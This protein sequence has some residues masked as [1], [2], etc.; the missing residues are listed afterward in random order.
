SRARTDCSPVACFRSNP[1]PTGRELRRGSFTYNTPAS[2]TARVTTPTRASFDSPL[3]FAI[4]EYVFCNEQSPVG[5]P[6]PTQQQTWMSLRL[7][8]HRGRAKP[9]SATL[10][11]TVR[12]TAR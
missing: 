7:R 11:Q 2:A 4:E 5:K 12:G 8:K 10:Q 6:S 3:P 1:V 9:V